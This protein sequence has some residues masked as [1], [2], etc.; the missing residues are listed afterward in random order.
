MDQISGLRQT[1]ILPALIWLTVYNMS[2]TPHPVYPMGTHV[3]SYRT[4]HS[5]FNVA[6]FHL[7]T[8]CFQHS[9]SRHTQNVTLQADYI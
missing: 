6:Q 1:G 7:R 5:I 4:Y 9:F 3:L 2:C 8:E